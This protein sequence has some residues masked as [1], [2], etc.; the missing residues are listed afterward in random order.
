MDAKP[1]HRDGVAVFLLGTG[2][3]FGAGNMSPAVPELAADF[4]L[5]LSSVGLLAGTVY[6]A[7]VVAGLAVAPALAERF[8]VLRTMQLACVLAGLGSLLFAIGPDVWVLAVGRVLA[9]L[10]LGL[11]ATLGPVFARETGGVARVGVFGGAFQLGIGLGLVSGSLLA[12]AGVDWRVGFFVS[13]IAGFSALP[14]LRES[15][16]EITLASRSG[17]FLALAVRTPRVYRLGA[18]FIAM[19][20]VPLTLGAWLVHYLSVN[21]GLAVGV[22][23]ILSFLMFG[24]SALFRTVGAE[25]DSRGVSKLLLRGVMPLLATAGVALIAFDQSFAVALLAVILMAAGFALP[26]AVM[27][28]AAQALYPPEPADPVALLTTIASGIP[29]ALIPVVG[30]A[31]SEGYGE[32]VLL[33]LA[34]FIALAGVV[35]LRPADE[36]LAA[37]QPPG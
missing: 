16:S 19:F 29:I 31:L 7:A 24:A 30:A 17:G 3:A 32:E 9:G 11:A 2:T 1:S 36:P 33:G 12:D 21:G 10:G 14:L 13:A 15:A 4:S 23:G 5:S 35:N 18:L 27:V 25:L 37:R 6:F 22:A 28:V 34:A 26:Y 20:T 8:G